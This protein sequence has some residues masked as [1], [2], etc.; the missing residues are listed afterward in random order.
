MDNYY[1]LSPIG[2]FCLMAGGILDVNDLD[3]IFATTGLYVFTVLL[4]LLL[5]GLVVL[6][7]IYFVISGSHPFKLIGNVVQALVTAF[8]TSSSIA[9]LP[10]TVSCVEDKHG[11][12]PRVA[13][14]V[15]PLGAAI[16]MDGTALYEAVAALFLVQLHGI[17]LDFP[18]IVAVSFIATIASIGASGIPHAG[19]VTMTMLMNVLGLPAESIAFLIPVDWILHRF[20]TTV[21]VL[22]DVIGASLVDTLCK[23]ELDEFP[24][25]PTDS[26]SAQLSTTEEDV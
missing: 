6:P 14:F 7:M 19:L 26:E 1:R 10:A 15:L 12:D 18:S 24:I 4:G 2:V 16:N 11:V 25:K 13:R 9:A 3:K 17:P 20:R 22:G 23:G 8:G 21:N 5:H